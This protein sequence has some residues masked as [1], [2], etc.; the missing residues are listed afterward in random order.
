MVDFK[1]WEEYPHLWKTKA[2]YM[3]FIRGGIRRGLWER[4]PVKLEFINEN[5][6][7]VPLGRK[8]KTNPDGKVWGAICECCGNPFRLNDMNVDHK[9]G[10]STLKTVEDV[11]QF[12]N[13]I[14]FVKKEDLQFICKGCHKQKT[15]SE[16]EGV[17][18]E[19]AGI[20]KQA[21]E[22][23][24]NKQDKDWLEANNLVPASNAKQR[25]QQI[26]DK[27]KEELNNA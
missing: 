19:E 23:Q 12:V 5:R 22:I 13:N 16:R 27:L 11:Q 2:Q 26:I 8:T 3:S 4:N 9:V 24:K 25:R 18:F 15:Y 17:T 6:V 7:K 14:V 1:P 10:E 21:I 20:I